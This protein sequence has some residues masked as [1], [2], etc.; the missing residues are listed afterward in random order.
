[1]AVVSTDP[2]PLKV[3]PSQATNCAEPPSDAQLIDALVRGD[4]R[5]AGE[6][7]DRLVS[8]VDQ[9]LVRILG[10]REHDHDDLMQN[11]FEQII[12]SLVG[13]N[14]MGGCSL[15]TWANR[16]TAHVALNSIR[17]RQRERKVIDRTADSDFDSAGL[18][19]TE[20]EVELA[21]LRRHLVELSGTHAEMLVLHDL[22]G[23]SLQEIAR[24]LDVSEAAAQSRLVR[25]RKEL[26]KRLL[27][28]RRLPGGA[29]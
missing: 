10:R 3:L 6:L 20:A 21:R 11:A 17:A 13:G 1:V 18:P 14:F 9:T 23:H 19:R 4:S 29:S 7:H 22:Y 28:E 2:F 25:G 8:V 12:R 15:R 26:Q 27:R 16:I 5:V 24:L